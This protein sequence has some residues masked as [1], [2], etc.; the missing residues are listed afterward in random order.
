MRRFAI[1]CLALGVWSCEAFGQAESPVK[2]IVFLSGPTDHGRPQGKKAAPAGP[3]RPQ[4][5]RQGHQYERDL[6]LLA[7]CLENSPNLKGKIKTKVIV[8]KLPSVSELENAAAIV[9]ES[10]GD[11]IERETHPLFPPFST[12]DHQRYDPETAEKLRAV[13]ALVKKGMGVV[14]FHYAWFADHWQ[15]RQYYLNWLGGVWVQMVSKNPMD[16]WT[17]TPMAPA[18]PILRGVKPWTYR[19]EIFC[20][21]FLPNDP[22]RTDL[23]LGTPAKSP[24]GPQVAAWAYEAE[25]GHRGFAFG[26]LHD[27]T[28]LALEDHRRFVLNGIVW[29]AGMDV[30]A[31][32]VQSSVTEED[33]AK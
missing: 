27:H 10:S 7:H 23:L 19:E 17:M 24:I 14:V 18:H 31:G 1:A 3:A 33:I 20:R 5:Q 16:E 6:R 15:A 12:T 13:D 8:G 26:G 30:P 2:E 32:G 25:D 21:F 22:R 28:N 4:R 11:W 9:I 29:A